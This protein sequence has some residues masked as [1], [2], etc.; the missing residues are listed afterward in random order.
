[1]CVY[2]YIMTLYISS[3]ENPIRCDCRLQWV[4]T[5]LHLNKSHQFTREL[6]DLR[7]RPDGENQTLQLAHLLK[8]EPCSDSED[9]TTKDHH[10]PVIIKDQGPGTTKDHVPRTTKDHELGTTKDRDL[11]TTNDRVPAA[12]EK[13]SSLIPYGVQSER[14]NNSRT[15]VEMGHEIQDSEAIDDDGNGPPSGCIALVGDAR[16]VLLV[17]LMASLLVR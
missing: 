16:L 17:T 5:Y 6:Q 9:H 13:V 12:M 14:R 2:K 11:G 1:M 4:K 10:V 8:I 15:V 7:C 3:T